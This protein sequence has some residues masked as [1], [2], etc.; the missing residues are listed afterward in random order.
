MGMATGAAGGAGG[1]ALGKGISFAGDKLLGVAGKVLP[2]GPLKLP[3]QKKPMTADQFNALARQKFAEA[4]SHGV[5]FNRD[6]LIHLRDRIRQELADK[7][8]HPRNQPGLAATLETLDD[9]IA[10]GNATQRGMQTLR[11]ITSGGYQFQNRKN[12]MLVGKVIDEIDNL[13]TR[14]DQRFVS[15]NVSQSESC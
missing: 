4:E 3:S 7:G 12:N 1:Y 5:V 10:T 15:S 8:Y 2:V 6:G 13:S 9:Y 14:M 11:E